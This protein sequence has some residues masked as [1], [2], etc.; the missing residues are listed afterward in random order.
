[1]DNPQPNVVGKDQTDYI[2]REHL[3]GLL[4]SLFSNVTDTADFNIRVG[5]I[6]RF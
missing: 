6:I 4:R 3:E 5:S 2:S 1:M